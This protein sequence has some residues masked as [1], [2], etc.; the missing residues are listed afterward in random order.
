MSVEF[1]FEF[2]GRTDDP[3]L[4]TFEMFFRIGMDADSGTSCNGQLARYP[5][6]WLMEQQDVL[7]LSLSDSES[8]SKTYDLSD[9]GELVVGERYHIDIRFDDESLSVSIDG[10]S[11]GIDTS[12]WSQKWSKTWSRSPTLNEHI[13]EVVPVWWMSDKFGSTTYNIGGGI[14]E[15]V[16]ISSNG[17]DG[18]TL[19]TTPVPALSELAR[20]SFIAS[21]STLEDK[22]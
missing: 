20:N 6:L 7:L 13:G 15:N 8:C 4:G 22:G 17:F 14:F 19:G 16:I 21:E 10:I 1:D 3:H 11:D 18:N 5:A 9:F 12:F 2:T